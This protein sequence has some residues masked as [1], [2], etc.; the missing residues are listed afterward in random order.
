MSQDIMN[1][2]MFLVHSLTLGAV[3]TFVYDGFLILRRL[4][5]HTMLL[6]SLEDMIFWIGCAIGVFFM[7]YEENNGILRW[8]AVLGAGIGMLLYKKTLSPVIV[9]GMTKLLSFFIRLFLKLFRLLVRP[10]SF[11]GRKMK[12]GGGHLKRKAGKIRKY[13]RNK[14]T[15]FRKVLKIILCKH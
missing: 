14:L 10:A 12:S 15:G 9:G 7:L 3:I 13:L 5:K 8:F 11:L 4:V 1:E 6:I 2:V